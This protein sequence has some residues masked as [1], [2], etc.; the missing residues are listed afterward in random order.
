MDATRSRTYGEEAG[1]DGET[2]CCRIGEGVTGWGS[3]GWVDEEE[4]CGI[5]WVA[6]E[7]I[8]GCGGAEEGGGGCKSTVGMSLVGGCRRRI[9]EM[10]LRC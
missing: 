3:G 5:G 9:P 8:E 2:A 7:R 1:R 10:K 4:G 6:N